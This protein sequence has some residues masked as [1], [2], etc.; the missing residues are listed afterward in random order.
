MANWLS[1]E[2]LQPLIREFDSHRPLHTL[3]P[4]QRLQSVDRAVI[5]TA[6]AMET[7]TPI[8]RFLAVDLKEI[9]SDLPQLPNRMPEIRKA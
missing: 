6:E 8:M 9:H 4:H 3:R 2:G 7:R 5:A 1:R